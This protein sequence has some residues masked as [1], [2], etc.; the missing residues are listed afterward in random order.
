[1][2]SMNSQNDNTSRPDQPRTDTRYKKGQSGNPKGRPKKVA[3]ELDPGKSLQAIDNELISVKSNGRMVRI[4]KVEIHI[5][6]LFTRAIRRDMQAARAI[7]AM[8]AEYFAPDAVGPQ[9][10]VFIPA[11]TKPRIIN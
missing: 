2:K 5:Q 11:P 1:M 4:T 6:Q 3:K 9:Q 7:F 10:I 8:A